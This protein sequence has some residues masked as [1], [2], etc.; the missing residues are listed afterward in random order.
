MNF[1]KLWIDELVP[2]GLSVDTIA[3]TITMAGLEVD[4]VNPVCGEFTNVVVG[5]VL[6]CADHP[7]SDHLHVTTVNVGDEVLDIVCGAPNCRAGLKVACAKVGAV[8][9]GNFKIKPAKLRGVPSNG[10]LCSLKELEL[11]EESNGI[12]EFPADAPVGMDIHE[13]LNLN[14]SS[15][16]VDLTANRA[17]CLSIRGI[18][19]ELGVLTSKDVNY[20][21]ISEVPASVSDTFSV[22]VQD[23]DACPR[24]LCRVI[25]NV[26]I[27]RP[28]PL[29]MQEKLRRCG[30][31]SIDAIVDITN[32]ILLELGQPMHAFDLNKLNG[33]IIVRQAVAGE[34]LVLLSGEEAELKEGTLVIADKSGPIALAGIF[35][36]AATGVNA[37]T[38]DVLLES[39]FFAP[40]AIKN[41]AREYG[42]ATDAS[43]RYE[44]G[45]DYTITREAM[46]RAIS[47]IL[48]VCGGEAGPV[49]E[50]VSPEKFPVRNDINVPFSFIN[51]VIGIDIPKVT[52]MDILTRLGMKPNE[53]ADGLSVTVTSPSWR[54]DIAIPVDICEEVARIYGYD[55]IPNCDPVA[56]LRMIKQCEAEVTTYDIKSVLA[57]NG[58]HEVVTYSFVDPAS[59]KIIKPETEAIILPSPI[60]AEMSAMRTTIWA[61]LINTVLYN[62]N[63]QVQR[64][65][66]FECGLT[67]IKDENAENGI[68]QED[69]I[70]GAVYGTV[71]DES[72]NTESRDV[73]F[74][75]VKGDVER[76]LEV[77]GR[78]GDF[79]FERADISA[80]HPGVS[81]VI[82]LDGECVGY[83]GLIHPV[84]Q[85]KLGLKRPVFLFDLK[86]AALKTR[87]IPAYAEISKYPSIKRDFAILVDASVSADSIIS[88]VKDCGSLVRNV[89]IFDVFAGNGVPEGKK[90]IAFSVILQSTEKTLEDNDISSFSDSVIGNLADKLGA[91]LR[92]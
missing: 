89:N 87:K 63:R 50:V 81:A 7:D 31:R 39:A 4:S 76:L 48:E 35:G 53:S 58:Y 82:K 32:Y 18:A 52:V 13:Y 92:D 25:K 34:K 72:W 5:E 26:D 54:Y 40:S 84:V 41:R 46:E 27:T 16:E 68:L 22:D 1:N 29:W 2:T 70:A 79:V 21:V 74:F 49:N 3:D 47:F 73:D 56:P 9:P 33:Q 15:V 30:I 90:S 85:K 8:L 44:R 11:S 10:M 91:V 12:I 66:L 59:L 69:H 6:T 71:A 75:D 14:D 38:R 23:S 61:G 24:Y 45:V 88:V 36:G 57:D 80:L 60:S 86:L 43:H 62:V 77:T 37:E 67:F 20:P 64:M 28:S 65:K 42:L 83:V 19:R 17:D 51:E 55:N 78:A